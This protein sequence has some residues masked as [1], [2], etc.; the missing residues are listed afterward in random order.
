MDGQKELLGMW[1][2]QTEGA[3]SGVMKS[4]KI[5]EHR[6]SSVVWLSGL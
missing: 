1:I 6:H 3:K 4:N 2:D 5:E